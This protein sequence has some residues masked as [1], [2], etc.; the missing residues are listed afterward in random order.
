MPPPMASFT[1]HAGEQFGTPIYTTFSP[2]KDYL[3][4]LCQTGKVKIW[5]LQTRL[6]AGKEK[7]INPQEICALNLSQELGATD[8]RQ[9]CL[10]EK[11][12]TSET[13]Y[14]ALMGSSG[15]LDWL[16][17]VKVVGTS[18]FELESALMLPGTNGRLIS[19]SGELYWQSSEGSICHI[20]GNYQRL[21]PTCMQSAE[22]IVFQIHYQKTRSKSVAFLNSVFK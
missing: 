9:I 1:L 18:N 21:S 2:R 4:I 6:G 17:H 3:A 22:Y 7:A 5:S 14:L 10:W 19:S 20:P 12:P 8:L 16:S 13:V 15:S 11:N